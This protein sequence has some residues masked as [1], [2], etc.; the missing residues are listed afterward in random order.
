MAIY[1]VTVRWMG[2]QGAPGYSNFH[3]HEQA[4]SPGA[5]DGWERVFAFFN[6]VNSLFP[7]DVTYLAEGEVAVL[8]ET[9]GM[10]TDYQTVSENPQPG[11]GGSTGGYSAAS[12]AVVT[13]NTNGVRNGRRVRG[14]T[15]LVPLG[16]NSYQSDGTL[17][18]SAIS[19]INEAAEELVGDG[20]DSGFSVYSRPSTGGDGGVYP[21]T[22]FRVPDMA[23]VLRS[24]R[25]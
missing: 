1:R 12:G 21:V 7:T 2:F 13:W 20:F 24:R 22:G 25:D 5:R 17:T 19:T 14:R 9:T 3:F 10:V 4:G 23:A 15:F 18:S 11:N 8:D 6:G 16:G